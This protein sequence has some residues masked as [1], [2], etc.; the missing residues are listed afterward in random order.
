MHDI[1]HFN[2]VLNYHAYTYTV[3]ERDETYR[4][5]SSLVLERERGDEESFMR[6]NPSCDRSWF[7]L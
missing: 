4:V 3:N 7:I 2:H 6:R 5:E 1:Y